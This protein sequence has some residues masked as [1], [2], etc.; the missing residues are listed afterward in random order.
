MKNLESNYLENTYLATFF[1]FFIF[2]FID[3]QIGNI[4]LIISLLLCL[5]NYKILYEI[6]LVNIKLVISI[7]IFSLYIFLIG[8][9]HNT[10][11]AELDNYF[12]FLLLLPLLLITLNESRLLSLLILSAYAGFLHALYCS[13]F[14]DLDITRFSGTSSSAIT[15]G[16]MCATLLVVC[17]YF[18]IYRGM[19][20]IHLIFAILIFS[21]LFILT[22]TRGPLIGIVM[23]LIYLAVTIK[24]NTNQNKNFIRPLLVLSILLVSIL[25]I[26]NQLGE[27]IKEINQI[28]LS[29][30]LKITDRSLRERVF[31]IIYAKEQIQSHPFVGMGPQNLE[32]KQWQYLKEKNIHESGII[33]PKDHLHNEFAD[34]SVKFGL[35]SLVLLFLIYFRLIRTG[36]NEHRVLLNILMITLISSQITQS[37]LAHHQAITFFIVLFY[38][39]QPK[40]KLS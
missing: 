22:G 27:R 25:L 16:N 40:T 10:P 8:F 20:S 31:Y 6:I 7:I 1:L 32:D 9:Y 37:Q 24:N 4:F 36:S 14:L 38:L 11:I 29:E 34:I 23:S 35:L 13:V 2:N 21:Y 19:K 28:N 18:F 5:I 17:I 30:P 3:R 26:P 15:Y 12:R 39:L 33:R